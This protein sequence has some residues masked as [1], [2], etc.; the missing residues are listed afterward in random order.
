MYKEWTH[1][2]HNTKIEHMPKR[3]NVN[4]NTKIEYKIG[5]TGQD[6][7][8]RGDGWNWRHRHL[9]VRL[10]KELILGPEGYARRPELHHYLPFPSWGEKPLTE[11]EHYKLRGHECA[12]GYRNSIVFD[13][14]YALRLMHKPQRGDRH[15][16]WE[17]RF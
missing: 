12:T 17:C 15:I 2:K 4:Y 9:R 11:P 8:Y 7:T 6:T 10:F 3:T 5:A 16:S 13:P 1:V 14:R